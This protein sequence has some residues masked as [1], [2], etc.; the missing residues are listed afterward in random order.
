MAIERLP[1]V[2]MP[3]GTTPLSPKRST[4][5]SMSIPSRSAA[6]WAN[7]VSWPW[8]CGEAPLRMTTRPLGLDGHVGALPRA[9]GALDVERDAGA[10]HAGAVRTRAR[11]S[12][13]SS[14]M[15]RQRA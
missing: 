8:P 11:R 14:A 4:T 13:R 2:P 10:A 15:S 1:N 9:A 3:R 12:T 5:S 7:V 6:I